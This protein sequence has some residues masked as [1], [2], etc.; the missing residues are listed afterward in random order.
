MIKIVVILGGNAKEASQLVPQ[1]CGAMEL[2]INEKT[3]IRG[4]SDK[5]QR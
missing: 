2:T 3:S 1:D 5:G 4:K